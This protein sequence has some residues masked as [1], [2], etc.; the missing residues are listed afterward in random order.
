MHVPCLRITKK[1]SDL[2]D[3][4]INLKKIQEVID[5]IPEKPEIQQMLDHHKSTADTEFKNFC[6]ILEH[7]QSQPLC[8]TVHLIMGFAE[9]SLLPM[10]ER[11]PG[12]L[13]CVTGLKFDYLLF[14]T[15]TYL[16]PLFTDVPRNIVPR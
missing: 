10:L 3:T 16:R 2:C 13:H 5:D 7:W 8:G 14:R 6:T 11:Q 15:R 1:G 4:C 9:K 12:H